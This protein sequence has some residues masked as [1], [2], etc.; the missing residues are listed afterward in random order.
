MLNPE[1]SFEKQK[2]TLVNH[3]CTIPH[4]C[5]NCDAPNNAHS[6]SS[7]TD[8]PKRRHYYEIVKVKVSRDITYNQARHIAF[9]IVEH[10]QLLPL[11]IVNEPPQQGQQTAPPSLQSSNNCPS[12]TT[13]TP[14]LAHVDVSDDT[15]EDTSSDAQSTVIHLSSQPSSSSTT[16]TPNTTQQNDE[17]MEE[18]EKEIVPEEEGQLLQ[19]HILNDWTLVN[20]D[21]IIHPDDDSSK[22]SQDT[23]PS[24]TLD[25]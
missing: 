13:T 22:L 5:R 17:E 14:P 3:D 4:S 1:K 23:Q 2:R 16:V 24:T 8:C 25:S 12:T 19:T 9:S 7:L 6:P 11:P 20:F 21:E 10:Q 15:D 18:E